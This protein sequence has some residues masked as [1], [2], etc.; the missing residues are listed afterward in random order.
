MDTFTLLGHGLITALQP[1]N[2]FYALIGVT[3]GT[4]VGVLPG[5]GPALT[6]ALLLPVTYKLDPGRLADHVRRH[7]LWRH[8]WR[9][10][11]LDPAQHA[12]RKRL[13]RHRARGQQDGA[14]GPRRPGAGDGGDRLVRGR[15]DRHDR[16]CLHRAVGGEVRAVVRPGRIFRADGA[17]LHDRVGGVRRFH[18]ARADRAVPRPGARPDRHRSADR[19]GAPG[20]RHSRSA[21]RHRGDDAGRGAVCRRRDTER[22]RGQGWRRR[23]GSSRSRA[24]SG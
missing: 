13:D 2:L 24:R 22:R 4:A 19:P 9:L 23:E 18:A 6:V 1:W 17:G 7:L 8:V 20:F 10:D 5:I 15:P 16:P 21:R 12:G 11:H 3:L 14:Q